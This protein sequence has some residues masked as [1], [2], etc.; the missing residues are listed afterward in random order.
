MLVKKSKIGV[1]GAKLYEEQNIYEAA[2]TAQALDSLYPEKLTPPKMWNPVLVSFV[3]AI[4]HCHHLAEVTRVLNEAVALESNDHSPYA[5]EA[6]G[7]EGERLQIVDKDETDDI[8]Q[9]KRAQWDE[10]AQ[11]M[12]FPDGWEARLTSLDTGTG[13]TAFDPTTGFG[14]SVQPFFADDA[15]PPM[16]LTVG[17]Y[18]PPGTLRDLTESLREELEAAAVADLGAAYAVS[19][20]LDCTSPFG[21]ALELVEVSI[22]RASS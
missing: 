18:Y 17:S 20:T 6:P 12:G 11:V 7:T 14:L 3:N 1:S 21:K 5:V 13:V 16:Y 4:L 19:V 10:R 15:G 2:L 9:L 22:R 8:F